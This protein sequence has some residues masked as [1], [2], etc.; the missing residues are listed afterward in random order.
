MLR[1]AWLFTLVGFVCSHAAIADAQEAAT[2]EQRITAQ[3]E[4]QDDWAFES[5]RYFFGV[6][7]QEGHGLQSQ[8]GAVD[9]R[10][11]EDMWVIEPIAAFSFRTNSRLSHEVVFPVDIVTAASPDALDVVSGASRHN[12]AFALDITSTYKADDFDLTFR[13]GPHFEENLRAFSAGPTLTFHFLEDNTVVALSGYVVA[14]AFDP[15]TPYG[16]DGGQAARVALSGNLDLTQVLSETTLADFSFGI[17][18]QSGDLQT[19]WNSV[20]ARQPADPYGNTTVRVTEEFPDNR[21]R[22]ATQLGLSQHIP[23][24]H[25]TA[26]ASYRLYVDETGVIGN[27]GQVELYQYLAPWFYAR[28]HGRL[29]HQNAINFWVPYLDEPVTG[30]GARTSDS[31]LERLVSREAG[32]KLVFLRDKAPAE[33]RANDSFNLSFLHY[34]RSNGLT[35]EFGSLGYARSF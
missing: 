32:L 10:G 11:S 35:V 17:T 12:Q 15:I 18:T 25:T 8:A 30:D 2:L 5:M 19:T 4:K 14:D 29:H 24:S 16:K 23:A 21:I 7:V 28:A 34:Q 27:T 26:K 6:F 9:S 22:T 33:L 31:D 13:W 20:I 3:E 1:R